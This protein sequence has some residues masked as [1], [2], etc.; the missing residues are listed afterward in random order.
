MQIYQNIT[1]SMYSCRNMPQVTQSY[2]N[3]S[4][5]RILSVQKCHCSQCLQDK[6]NVTARANGLNSSGTGS[7]TE[8]G[9]LKLREPQVGM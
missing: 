1:K 2:Q 7:P 5:C 9:N 3:T 6:G 4:P 8:T